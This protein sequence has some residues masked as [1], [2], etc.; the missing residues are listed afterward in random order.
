[1]SE[2]TVLTLNEKLG[3]EDLQL[4]DVRESA[5]YAGGRIKGAT[6]VPLGELE[7]RHPELDHS[8]P[9]YVI[10]RTGNRS[11]KA[12]KTL[13]ELG[14]TNVINV[15]G[16]FEAWKNEGLPFE[17]D[18]KAPW[19]IERQVRFAAGLF[20]LTGFVLSVFVHPYLIGISV[21]IGAGLVFSALTNTCAMGMIILKMPWNRRSPNGGTAKITTVI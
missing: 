2:C 12:Q 21:F 1:M 7:K 16:G 10:C 6:L 4:V 19:D 8:K 14:F 3:N 18:E 5:E 17:K 11:G 13:K 9:I 15:T 20:V